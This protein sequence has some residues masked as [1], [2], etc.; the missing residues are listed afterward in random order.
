MKRNHNLCWK[1]VLIIFISFSTF[2]I[3]NVKDSTKTLKIMCFNIHHGEGIDGVVDI[4]RIAKLILEHKVDLVA[5]QEV[6]IGVARTNRIDI[7][8]ILSEHTGMYPVFEKNIDYQGGEYGNGILSRYPILQSEN[9]HY[10]MIREGEQRGL[11]KTVV[12]VD[13]INIA[14]MNTHIDYRED[15]SERLSNVN[16]INDVI[17]KY[18]DMPVIVAGDFNDIPSSR[19]HTAMKEN[20]MDVWEVKGEGEGFTFHTENPD[21]R[22]D[23]IFLHKND[24]LSVKIIPKSI[25]VVYS[26]ASDHLPLIA[27]FI[28]EKK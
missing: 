9:H 28:I 6:D 14:F 13:G 2:I 27:E 12:D 21:K 5:L 24:N 8:K 3:G 22:I 26:I 7:M 23:Y 11:L 19:T 18:S 17:K 16:E 1:I 4:E 25:E 20:F 15:D 10:K